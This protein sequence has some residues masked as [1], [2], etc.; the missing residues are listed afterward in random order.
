[1]RRGSEAAALIVRKNN[2]S[3]RILSSFCVSRSSVTIKINFIGVIHIRPQS[4]DDLTE[5]MRPVKA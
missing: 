2:F 3:Y 4:F 1:M 5:P